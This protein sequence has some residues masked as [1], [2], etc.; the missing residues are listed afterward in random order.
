MRYKNRR[1]RLRV[2][3]RQAAAMVRPNW[4]C[5][6]KNK[7]RR[8]PLKPNSA[9]SR[10][11]NAADKILHNR[12]ASRDTNKIQNKHCRWRGTAAVIHKITSRG[13]FKCTAVDEFY[14]W[15]GT[16][17]RF[18]ARYEYTCRLEKKKKKDEKKPLL[19]PYRVV[20]LPY[21]ERRMCVIRLRLYLT[22]NVWRKLCF[23]TSNRVGHEIRI[24]RYP[25]PDL[26][27]YFFYVTNNLFWSNVVE[28]WNLMKCLKI[29]YRI[30]FIRTKN[31][32]LNNKI[33]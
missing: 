3:C 17:W 23:C 28:L 6:I 1:H 16:R 2:E 29:C 11:I 10:F 14:C 32:S 22:G 7:S 18:V 8:I 12:L 19:R 30:K 9:E 27:I 13:V 31:G 25:N 15:Y 4:D 33:E 20:F 24:C 5:Q 26:W 21:R